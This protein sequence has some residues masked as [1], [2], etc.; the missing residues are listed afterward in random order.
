[1]HERYA[2]HSRTSTGLTHATI[3]IGSVQNA[4]LQANEYIWQLF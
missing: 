4:E 2:Y 3:S 1:M